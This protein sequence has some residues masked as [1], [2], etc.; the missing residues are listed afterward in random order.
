MTIPSTLPLLGLAHGSRDL[1]SAAAIEELMVAVAALRP[2]LRTSAAF[3][4]LSDPDLP[5]A[6]ARLDV[7][8]AVVVPLL[9][10]Q[11]F[12]ATK[13]VPDA[14]QAAGRSTGTD[15]ITG[16]ILG[17]GPDVLAVLQV[18]A[19]AAGV[20]DD[21]EILLL[22]VGTSD[23]IAN[24]AVDDLAARWSSARKGGVRAVFATTA[25]RAVDAL[26]ALNHDNEPIVTQ[27]ERQS[28]AVV[29][30]FLAPGL[31]LDQVARRA[32]QLGVSVADPLWP[33]MAQVVLD[34][35]DAAVAE[36]LDR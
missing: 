13:D 22:A 5:T 16:K 3:L 15:L 23:P 20:P 21:Q 27:A 8:R 12:H 4:D 10:A 30:L 11:A 7:N 17:T 32:R 24:A 31:L 2:G 33:A 34:R 29:P 36:R 25:P 19:G 6:L 18:A 14:V 35:Y 26:D 1:R 9:F 28:P